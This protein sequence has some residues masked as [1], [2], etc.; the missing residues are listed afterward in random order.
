MSAAAATSIPAA[1]PAHLPD[2]PAL[3]MAML[4]KLLA[5]LRASRQEDERQRQRLDQ[6]L[7]R[8]YGPRS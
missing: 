8:L 7:R 2:D 1:D 4:A 3:L 5:A 6:L